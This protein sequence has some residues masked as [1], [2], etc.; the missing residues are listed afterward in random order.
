MRTLTLTRKQQ[1]V[2][3]FI[4]RFIE[5]H[6]YS[7]N[8]AEIA[9]G[10]GVVSKNSVYVYLNCLERQ[11]FITRERAR[12]RTIRITESLKRNEDTERSMS[13]VTD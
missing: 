2:L 7:P 5:Q 4:R 3:E 13:H 9:Q 11:G 8:F 6:H 12:P 10:I 1:V